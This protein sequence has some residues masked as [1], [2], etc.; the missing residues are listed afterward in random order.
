M[1]HE[2]RGD[3]RYQYLQTFL[4]L[5]KKP[6]KTQADKDQMADLKRKMADLSA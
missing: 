2:K 5:E 6:N 1:K 3:E 4:K